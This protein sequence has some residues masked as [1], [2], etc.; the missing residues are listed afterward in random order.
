MNKPKWEESGLENYQEQ[1]YNVLSD[2][3]RTFQGPEFI[4]ALSEMFS[5]MLVI[6]A[7]QNFDTTKSLQ[8]KK[9]KSLPAFSKEHIQAYNQHEKICKQWRTA[10]RP[11]SNLHPA[12]AAKLKSQRYM[13][14]IARHEESMKSL[15]LHAELMETHS[16]DI[17]K[18]CSKLK[19]IRG[20][21]TKSMDIPLIETLCGNYSG[22]NVLEGFCA[23]TEKLC[24]IEN[25]E[26]HEF[27]KMCQE[28]NQVIFEL[29]S[30][31]EIKIPHM[32]LSQLSDIIF[33]S[34]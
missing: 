8:N 24:N 16:K 33:K 18:V 22:S 29:T 5:K 1:T 11:Q 25:D 31:D 3:C 28:D 20:D 17:S 10:G 15:N 14:Q 7:E 13:Q 19:K 30:E 12:K 2:L 27:Y 4:P 21:K 34:G 26:Q 23:N 9:R 6:S 32:Q